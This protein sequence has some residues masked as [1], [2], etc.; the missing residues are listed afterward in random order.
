MWITNEV[1]KYDLESI[2]KCKFIPWEK[3]SNKEVF[4]TGATGL[5]GYTVASALAYYNLVNHSGIRITALVRDLEKAKNAFREQ[6]SAG[7]ELDFICGSVEELSAVESPVDYIIHCASPTASQYFVMNPVDTMR[8]IA[9]GTDNILKL[10]YEKQAAGV[11]YL[12][13]ME[14]F[15]EVRTRGKL[16]ETDLGYID[17]LSLRSSY[18]EGKRFA[19]SLCCA[20]AGQYQVPV[21]IARLAQTFGP[22]VKK[23]DKR[24]FAYMA[25]CAVNGE[26]IHLKTSGLK[27]NMYLYTM[28]A[29]SAILLLLLNG[30]RGT[31]YNVGNPETYCSVKEM[32]QLVARDL[33]DG[34]ISVITNADEKGREYYP[35]D[36]FLR[37]DVQKL[38]EAGWNAAIGL[39]EM[40]QRMVAGFEK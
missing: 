5:I 10:A 39:A 18:S 30:E 6:L 26:N 22:G 33:C 9:M 2:S 37:L 17:I 38:Q 21:T 16:R 7:C 20:Y 32:G 8:T 27:E 31:S 19:E 1:F 13:S 4:I 14:V 3:L 29:A 34:K 24:V 23:D 40:F 35:P 25:R 36:S 15:G 11:V 12:S 28:D